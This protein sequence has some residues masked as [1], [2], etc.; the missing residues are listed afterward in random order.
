MQ[1]LISS[2]M[3]ILSKI[4]QSLQFYQV[5]WGHPKT[6][7]VHFIMKSTAWK[8]D[9]QSVCQCI[10]QNYLTVCV[11][12]FSACSNSGSKTQTPLLDCFI[13]VLVV[14]MLPLFDQPTC[15][16]W[17]PT[18]WPTI[19]NRWIFSFGAWHYFLIFYWHDFVSSGAYISQN[20]SCPK[21]KNCVGVMEL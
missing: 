10:Y 15:W 20:T 14:E 18:N 9:C 19:F 1:Q 16:V 17:T 12:M 4:C 7:S 21:F 13:D 6:Q 2:K 5:R 3:P 11:E 8:C